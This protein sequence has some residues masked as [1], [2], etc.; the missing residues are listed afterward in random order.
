LGEEDAQGR[1]QR[2]SDD[3]GRPHTSSDG[4]RLCR[5]FCRHVGGC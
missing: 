5:G 2:R 1:C 3:E 4:L